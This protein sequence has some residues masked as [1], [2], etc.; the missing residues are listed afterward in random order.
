[1][2]RAPRLAAGRARA[3]GLPTRGT[4][5]PNRLRR[6][7]RWVRHACRDVLEGA[8]DPLV[9]DLGYG[10]SPVTTVELATRLRPVNPRLRV[11]GLELDADRVAA[12][13][14]AADPPRLEFRRGGFELAGRR[15]VLLRAFNVLRQYTEEQAAE[16]WATMRGRLAPGGVLVEGTCDEIGRRC[17]WVALTAQGPRTLTLSCLPADLETPG[18]LAERLPKALIH[19]NVPGE[20][21]HALLAELDACWAAAATFAPFGPRARWVEAVALLA[22]RG[23]PVLDGRRRWRLGEVT[24][25]WESVRPR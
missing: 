24:V 13:Q 4:T 10:S 8:A 11:L 17:S 3:L 9:V 23:W 25:P 20:R 21:V 22:R 6:V 14:A 1:M 12:G 15:P 7:D 2:A 19:R 5:N 18:D 16:A